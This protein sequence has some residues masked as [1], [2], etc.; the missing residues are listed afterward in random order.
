MGKMGVDGEGLWQLEGRTKARTICYRWMAAES[1]PRR[2]QGLCVRM[3]KGKGIGRCVPFKDVHWRWDP[4]E[5][6]NQCTAIV[7]PSQPY[8]LKF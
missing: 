6:S 7:G 4:H 5:T 1:N 8:F 2:D 3:A